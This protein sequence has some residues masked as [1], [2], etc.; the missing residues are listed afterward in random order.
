MYC[1]HF[2]GIEYYYDNTDVFSMKELLDKVSRC[3]K[4]FIK[5]SVYLFRYCPKCGEMNQFPIA[6]EKLCKFISGES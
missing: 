6:V 2:V 4:E 1:D 3:N 5:E